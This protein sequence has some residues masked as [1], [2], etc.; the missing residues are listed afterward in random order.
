MQVNLLKIKSYH[1]VAG[2]IVK[3][4][5][6]LSD[7]ACERLALNTNGC[8]GEFSMSNSDYTKELDYPRMS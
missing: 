8:H 7:T 5:F 6:Y 4:K 3:P 1:D 2:T